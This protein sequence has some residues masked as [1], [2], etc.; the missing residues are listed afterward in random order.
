[1]MGVLGALSLGCG[2]SQPSPETAQA[3]AAQRLQGDWQLVSFTPE[4]AM[5]APLQGLLNAQLSTLVV[6]FTGTDYTAHGPGLDAS[7]RYEITSAQGDAFAGRIY[8]RAGAG[9]GV[10]GTFHGAELNFVGADPPWRGI[11]T[12][13]RPSR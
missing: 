12:L 11:G 1:M 8:D 6:T 10:S 9:Y 3:V 13:R 5:E 7:G 2:S 4:L